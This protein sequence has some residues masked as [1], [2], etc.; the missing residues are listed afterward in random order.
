MFA[1]MLSLPSFTVCASQLGVEKLEN[2]L[3]K[4]TKSNS[5]QLEAVFKET[6][7]N[8]NDKLPNAYLYKVTNEDNGF[9][10]VWLTADHK[11]LLLQKR[12]LHSFQNFKITD[13]VLTDEEKKLLD[14]LRA[15]NIEFDSFGKNRM[16]RKSFQLGASSLYGDLA[17]LTIKQK[18]MYAK[19]LNALEKLDLD[20]IFLEF[21]NGNISYPTADIGNTLTKHFYKQLNLIQNNDMI[22]TYESSKT[23][24][25]DPQVLLVFFHPE[26]TYCKKLFNEKEILLAKNYELHL[27]PTNSW[28]SAMDN[29]QNILCLKEDNEIKQY[30]EK[31]VSGQEVNCGYGAEEQQAAIMRNIIQ[32]LTDMIELKGTPHTIMLS[33]MSLIQ[34]YIPAEKFNDASK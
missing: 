25:V 2:A 19:D 9:T 23:T 1:I 13:V 18:E 32:N 33:D 20:F 10:N 28:F 29:I 31:V 5:F 22:V 8:I 21:N 34:G 30:Y 7:N 26:C 24:K 17:G 14:N 12:Q 3:N 15:N 16:V 27:V 11:Y 4:L 6:L